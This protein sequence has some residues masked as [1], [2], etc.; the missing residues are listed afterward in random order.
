MTEVHTVSADRFLAV[1][2]VVV[3]SFAVRAAVGRLS[4]APL[5]EILM[6]GLRVCTAATF[7]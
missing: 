6:A 5:L 3:F 7:L 2:A 4:P 1:V